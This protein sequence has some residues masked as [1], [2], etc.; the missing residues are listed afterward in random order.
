M[1]APVWRKSSYSA[2]N[3]VCVEVAFATA[4]AA[5]WRK[6]SYSTNNGECVE[7]A[8]AD[9]VVGARDSKNPG[10]PELWFGGAR[11]GSFVAAIKAL[12]V[13]PRMTA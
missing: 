1:S 12:A 4:D 3:G 9:E 11:W 2:N 13:R 8:L 6:S 10:G 5:G 7:V